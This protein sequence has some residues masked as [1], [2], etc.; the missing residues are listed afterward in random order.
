[1]GSLDWSECLDGLLPSFANVL[2]TE[3]ILQYY[4][5]YILTFFLYTSNIL[6]CVILVYMGN[7]ASNM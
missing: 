6:V 3:R 5:K 2:N 7:L 4:F 1:M